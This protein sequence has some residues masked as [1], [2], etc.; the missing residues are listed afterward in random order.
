MM[1]GAGG[2]CGPSARGGHVLGVLKGQ[3]VY[4]EIEQWY[5]RIP[6]MLLVWGVGRTELL[7]MERWES[8]GGGG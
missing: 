4:Q 6:M 8:V 5:E 3:W 7:S 2:S 1:L